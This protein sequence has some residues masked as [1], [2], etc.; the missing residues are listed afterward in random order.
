MRDTKKNVPKK[1]VPKKTAPK[2][3]GAIPKRY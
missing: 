1:I 3:A 2:K